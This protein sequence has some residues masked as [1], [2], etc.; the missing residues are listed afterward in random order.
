MVVEVI[1]AGLLTA[2][3]PV[4]GAAKVEYVLV[5]ASISNV[6][7]W[8]ANE[9]IDKV[10]LLSD[11]GLCCL[12]ISLR[13]DEGEIDKEKSAKPPELFLCVR[14]SIFFFFFFCGVSVCSVCLSFCLWRLFVISTSLHQ[15][16]P[17][18]C[19]LSLPFPLC[20]VVTNIAA[21]LT[22]TRSLSL[23]PLSYSSPLAKKT[24]SLAILNTQTHPLSRQPTTATSTTTHNSISTFFIN[25][26]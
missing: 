10:S 17:T 22:R 3:I 24:L 16:T 4:S 5:L 6:W 13:T 11:P 7:L 1:P 23:S 20:F 12:F 21:T 8:F 15:P 18:L 25:P 9:W 19:P 14:C 2:K 26:Q